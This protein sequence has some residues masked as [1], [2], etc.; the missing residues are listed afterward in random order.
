MATI[1]VR[2]ALAACTHTAAYAHTDLPLR[3]HHSPC[4]SSPHR[5]P[6]PHPTPPAQVV[7]C[8]TPAN[9]F[10]ILRRQ[11]HRQFRKPLVMF[12]PKNLLRH[13]LAK[14]P[15]AEFSEAVADKD[16]NI[17]VGTCRSVQGNREV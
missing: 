6:P 14:S 8:T 4:R 15:L 1:A 11:L 2:I 12:A 7:N 17:Q 10:H 5:I 9:Y 16:K 3:P 13:P